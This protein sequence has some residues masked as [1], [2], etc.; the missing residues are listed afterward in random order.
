M[1]LSGGEKKMVSISRALALNPENLDFRENL[2]IALENMGMID[3]ARSCWHRICEL[4][5][6]SDQAQRACEVLGRS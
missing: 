1:H 4:A 6:D 2:A 5:P 3:R